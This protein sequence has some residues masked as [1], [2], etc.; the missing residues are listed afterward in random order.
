MA[1]DARQWCSE[2]AG[3]APGYRRSNWSFKACRAGCSPLAGE[4]GAVEDRT[5]AHHVGASL[6]RASA[7]AA[8]AA[9]AR[10]S[11]R[12]LRN[13]KAPSGIRSVCGPADPAW[14]EECNAAPFLRGAPTLF[15]TLL[16]VSHFV[17]PSRS[18]S[19]GAA[20]PKR[21]DYGRARPNLVIPRRPRLRDITRRRR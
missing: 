16:A 10:A 3:G 5:R 21:W 17:N 11:L 18:S 15:G 9:S 8:V 12:S 19:P 7:L 6:Y 4:A 2:R 14:A 13:L 1:A 20:K